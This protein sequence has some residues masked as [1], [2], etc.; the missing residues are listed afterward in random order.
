MRFVDIA[1]TGCDLKEPRRQIRKFGHCLIWHECV[2]GYGAG[3]CFGLF[4][5]YAL[6]TMPISQ[7]K[8]SRCPSLQNAGKYD[9]FGVRCAYNIEATGKFYF[10]TTDV[11]TRQ[12]CAAIEPIVIRPLVYCRHPRPNSWATRM[13]LKSTNFEIPLGRGVDTWTRPYYLPL[14]ITCLGRVLM[15]SNPETGRR[16]FEP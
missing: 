1:L 16:N 15:V 13:A 11:A 8:A 14:V 9:R 2:R 12:I 7:S 10:A 6:E 3:F 5:F 4:D